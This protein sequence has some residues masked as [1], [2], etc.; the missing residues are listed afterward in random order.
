M[1]HRKQCILLLG[2]SGNPRERRPIGFESER[3]PVHPGRPCA[4]PRHDREQRC[5]LTRRPATSLVA[6]VPRN[7]RP[8]GTCRTSW[9]AETKDRAR[10]RSTSSWRPGA[11][12]RQGATGLPGQG[13][14]GA[15]SASTTS[16]QSRKL[17]VDDQS[18]RV[19]PSQYRAEDARPRARRLSRTTVHSRSFKWCAVRQHHQMAASRRISHACSRCRGRNIPSPQDGWQAANLDMLLPEAGAVYVVDRLCPPL[20]VAQ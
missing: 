17:Y 11:N 15:G 18:H 19:A 6:Q 16:R 10:R 5:W 14:R 20:C 1:K 2:T 12:E 9:L 7:S 13:P 4:Q 3:Q 8:R